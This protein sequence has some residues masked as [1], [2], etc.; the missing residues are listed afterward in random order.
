[1][2]RGGLLATIAAANAPQPHRSVG[3]GA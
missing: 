1:V 2:V 3:N